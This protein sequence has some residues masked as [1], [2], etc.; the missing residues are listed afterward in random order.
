VKLRGPLKEK[1][2]CIIVT[3]GPFESEVHI[4]TAVGGPFESKEAH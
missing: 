3:F 2:L 1:C 4:T